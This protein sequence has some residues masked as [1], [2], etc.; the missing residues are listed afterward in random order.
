MTDE[1]S[2]PETAAMLWTRRS[3][4]VW[5]AAHAD[6]LAGGTAAEACKRRSLSLSTFR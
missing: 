5:A 4:A 6:Y 2:E 3:P 1:L